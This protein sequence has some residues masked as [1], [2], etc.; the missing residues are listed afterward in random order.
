MGC[1][2]SRLSTT[3]NQLQQ[4][5]KN[6]QHTQPQEQKN[7]LLISFDSRTIEYIRKNQ[8]EIAS[9]LKTDC[10]KKLNQKQ[11]SSLSKL[12]KQTRRGSHQLDTSDSKIYRSNQSLNEVND[13]NQHLIELAVEQVINYAINHYKLNTPM[14]IDQLKQEIITSDL[15]T[16]LD[17]NNNNVTVDINSRA[18]KK[19]LNLGID[20]LDSYLK[21]NSDKMNEY[22][23]ETMNIKLA[24]E[25]EY[26][27]KDALEIARQMFYKG[28]YS[29]IYTTK[30]GGYIVREVVDDQVPDYKVKSYVSDC[31]KILQQQLQQ[32][33]QQTP[34]TFNQ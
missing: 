14:T 22:Q 27:L 17:A 19:A 34:L 2:G 28:K 15:I 11:S 24:A 16:L 4:Q 25:S 31:K 1:S 9:K 3:S 30:S 5:Q 21:E 13:I 7:D 29:N 8:S 6:H 10:D 23:T 18:Y 33:Q 20:E 32:Q 12:L 26:K